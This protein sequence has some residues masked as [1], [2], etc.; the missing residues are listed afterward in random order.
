MSFLCMNKDYFTYNFLFIRITVGVNNYIMLNVYS[1]HKDKNEKKWSN[2]FV[3]MYVHTFLFLFCFV[4]TIPSKTVVSV[5]SPLTFYFTR[6]AK[7]E[8]GIHKTG[9]DCGYLQKWV[10]LTPW[11]NCVTAPTDHHALRAEKSEVYTG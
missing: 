5:W 1:F 2:T 7:W 8:I 11:F 9:M 6:G 10:W 3:L 4:F